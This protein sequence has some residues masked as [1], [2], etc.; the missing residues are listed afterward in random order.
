MDQVPAQL[1]RRPVRVDPG[2]VLGQPV[3]QPVTLGVGPLRQ[4]AEVDVDVL[5]RAHQAAQP[6]RAQRRVGVPLPGRALHMRDEPA[7]RGPG[8][9][10]HGGR[11]AR[12]DARGQPLDASDQRTRHRGA[13]LVQRG[14]GRI[15]RL[16]PQGQVRQ[17]GPLAL[18]RRGVVAVVAGQ[19]HLGQIGQRVAPVQFQLA[20]D[21]LGPP[22][23]RGQ[24]R[25]VV[26]I[27]GPVAG[28]GGLRQP[29][30]AVPHPAGGEVLDPAVV[31][32]AS[33]VLACL[34]DIEIADRPDPQ[35]KVIHDPD[36]IGRA[37][38]ACGGVSGSRAPAAGLAGLRRP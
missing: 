31:L 25:L 4:R 3:Q 36:A 17:L 14:Q 26:R 7:V 32:V 22:L 16:R 12:R 23:E 35:G 11:G 18:L 29:G 19:V 1:Q 13:H 34:G 30:Q 21:H 8:G 15:H 38:L 10:G 37:G 27:A 20:V 33:A 6:G 24:V 2:T 28:R 5:G 9:R